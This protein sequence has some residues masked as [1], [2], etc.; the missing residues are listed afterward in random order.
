[1]AAK[2]SF[3][4]SAVFKKDYPHHNKLEVAFM[5]RSNA[6]KSSL[7]NIFTEIKKIK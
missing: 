5:G 7:I 2:I 3:I 6:G 1:M 4:K